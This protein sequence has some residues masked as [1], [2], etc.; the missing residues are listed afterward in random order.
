MGNVELLDKLM[1]FEELA[2]NERF[3]KGVEEL[4]VS[5]ATAFSEDT[6]DS[7]S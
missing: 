6:S 7:M 2:T 4:K 1:E 3:K 5:T